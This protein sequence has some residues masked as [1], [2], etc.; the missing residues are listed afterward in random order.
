MRPARALVAAA[1]IHPGQGV[2]GTSTISRTLPN[3]IKRLPLSL[4]RALHAVTLAAPHS[5]RL[6]M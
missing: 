1:T 4:L 5:G 3:A 2:H 6:A